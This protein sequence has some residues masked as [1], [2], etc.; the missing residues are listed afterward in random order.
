[1]TVM[2]MASPGKTLIHHAWRTKSRPSLS[3]R[4]QVGV[5]GLTPKPEIGQRRFGENAETDGEGELHRHRR[6]QV[7]PD[8]A[9]HHLAVARAQRAGRHGEVLL[10]RD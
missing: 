8:V 5:A 3:A 10:S 2:T 9:D 4:P 6:H 1:M 7:R